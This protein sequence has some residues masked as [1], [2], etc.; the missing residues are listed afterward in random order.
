M[1][2]SGVYSAQIT[3]TIH[4]TEATRPTDNPH[5]SM[6]NRLINALQIVIPAV[7]FAAIIHDGLTL[8]TAQHS[9]TQHAIYTTTK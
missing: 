9:G 8:K 6:K 3:A 7:V 1:P 4:P 2:L 5:H